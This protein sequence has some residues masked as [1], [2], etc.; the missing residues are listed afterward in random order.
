MLCRY[1][2]AAMKGRLGHYEIVAELGRGGMGVVHK[3]L[4]PALGRIVAIKELAPA[5]ADDPALVERFLR[6]ARSMA[7][8]SDPHIVGIHFIG[9]EHGR[10]FFVME[11]VEG[12]ALGGM[13]RRLGKLPV[14]DAL[15]ILQ[16]TAQ[17]L[18]TAHERGVIHRDIKPGNI[19]VDVK[20]RVRIADFG[21]ALPANDPGQK[22]TG[23]GE[24]IGTPGYVSPELCKGL[25]IDARSDIF[26]LGVVLFEMLSGRMPFTDNS[27][28]GLMLEVVNAQIPDIHT[29]NEEVDDRT[30]AILAKMVAKNPD[31]RYQS[32]R[33]LANDLAQHPLVA[34]G[35]PLATI[36]RPPSDSETVIAALSQP[37]VP[38]PPPVVSRADAVADIVDTRPR[39][40]NRPH[41][42]AHDPDATVARVPVS[43]RP[44]SGRE[45]KIAAVALVALVLAGT[46]FAFRDYF[47]GFANGFRDGFVAG[48]VTNPVPPSQASDTPVTALAAP[49]SGAFATG[50]STASTPAGT[51]T[52]AVTTSPVTATTS[53]DASQQVAGTD[54]AALVSNQSASP[55]TTT[56]ATEQPASSASTAQ[57]SPAA[58]SAAAVAQTSTTA[59]STPAPARPTQARVAPEPPPPARVVVIAQ[60]DSALSLPA[61]QR[62]E[63]HL[64]GDGHRLLDAETVSGLSG[65][66]TAALIRAARRHARVLVIVR[67]E[68]IGSRDLYFHGRHDVA[69]T[70]YLSVRAYDTQTGQPISSGFRQKVEFAALNADTRARETVDPEMS[71]LSRAVAPVLRQTSRG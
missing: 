24:F 68:P 9:Q 28:L 19:L 66:D 5:L 54:A 53:A 20:G 1:W 34:N 59:S 32:A 46:A 45:R 15:K 33:E 52:A 25:P 37:R 47:S 60:G 12:E 65:G 14:A 49:A 41:V 43:S 21:I 10:P 40:S 69:Y 11:F 8:L 58:T 57:A 38:T 70:A 67:A 42:A 29:L 4:D 31:E 63:D 71:S 30:A 16:Q 13:L 6:E 18:A 7:A 35:K 61:Q 55:T 44:A 39:V 56:S 36:V 2:E 48:K 64:S 26:S 22:L 23:T 50:D 3:A 62:V 51:D 17:G 27:P